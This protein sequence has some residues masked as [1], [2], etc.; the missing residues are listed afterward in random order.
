MEG[1]TK[2]NFFASQTE[3]VQ[4]AERNKEQERS[5]FFWEYYYYF[6]SK[7]CFIFSDDAYE[8]AIL[9][10]DQSLEIETKWYLTEKVFQVRSTTLYNNFSEKFEQQIQNNYRNDL[11]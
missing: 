9:A 1:I 3:F 6:P 7:K 4:Q 11:L 10:L 5:Q 2:L 8:M